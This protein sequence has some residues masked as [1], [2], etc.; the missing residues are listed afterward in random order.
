M[1]FR[2]DHDRGEREYL[3]RRG[4]ATDPAKKD[5]NHGIQVVYTLL[6]VDGNGCPRIAFL[7]DALDGEPDELLAGDGKPTCSAESMASYRWKK[8]KPGQPAKEEPI[9]VD[10]DGA[11]ACRMLFDSIDEMGDDE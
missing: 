11:D 1:L 10:D 6:N 8:A 9:K 7:R 4:V 5:V 2:S 3:E